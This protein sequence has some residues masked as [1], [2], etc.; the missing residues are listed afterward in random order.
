[1]E[2]CW[3]AYRGDTPIDHPELAPLNADLT[4]QPPALVV[5]A[6]EDVLR[7]DG[8]A[9]AD[10]LRVAGVDVTFS[11]YDDMTHGFLRW[12]GVVD[13]SREL[14]CEVAQFAADRLG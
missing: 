10:A 14:L 12:G 13:R 1:M 8:E 7:S 9:Y 5:V 11:S 6:G 4:G 3:A 2:A